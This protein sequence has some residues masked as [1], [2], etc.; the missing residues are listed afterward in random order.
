LDGQVI[1]GH[2]GEVGP[3]QGLASL[4]LVGPA[5]AV[6]DV[7]RFSDASV[8]APLRIFAAA[9]IGANLLAANDLL[10]GRSD[11]LFLLVRHFQL[12][13]IQLGASGSN[14]EVILLARGCSG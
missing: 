11:G 6:E 9:D 2:V 10:F 12:S 14:G 8:L 3:E 5:F 13:C 4:H 1:V 7:S